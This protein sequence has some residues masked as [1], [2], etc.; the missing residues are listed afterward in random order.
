VTL[1]DDGAFSSCQHIKELYLPSSLQRIGNQGLFCAWKLQIIKLLSREPIEVG[2]DGLY[3]IR[4]SMCK[5]Y[6]P[7]GSKNA[8]KRHAAW[9]EFVREGSDGYDNIVEFGSAIT[10]RNA[11][12]FYGDEMPR[13][14]YSISGDMVTG[15]PEVWCDADQYSPAG[16][17]VIHVGPGTVTDEIV[18]YFDGTLTIWQAPLKVKVD[19]Y[20]RFEGEEN[21][22][23]EITISGYKLG[24]DASAL[25]QVP[26]AS[27]EATPSSPVGEYPIVISGGKADNYEFRYTHGVLTVLP[28]PTGI[29]NFHGNALENA[30]ITDIYTL[31]GRKVL[32]SDN[33]LK[34]LPSGIYVIK[35]KKLIVK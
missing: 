32:S 34:G 9:G 33:T 11:G 12:K 8:Y 1:I 15:I 26:E 5:L 7:A 6:V 21:P 29:T 16:S 30:G 25:T 28:D 31:D 24:E 22:E 23:F 10:A 14:G 19:N 35:G 4:K 3:G 18:E 13:L 17:Y 20:T 27:C 2:A